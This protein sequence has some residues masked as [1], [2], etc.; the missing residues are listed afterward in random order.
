[1]TPSIKQNYLL[2]FDLSFDTDFELFLPT[3]YLTYRSGKALYIFKKATDS[4][5]QTLSELS[6]SQEENSLLQLTQSL[7]REVLL[8]KF[9]KDKSKLQWS[10]SLYDDS[11]K[12]QYIKDYVEEKTHKI[13]ETISREQLLL[14]VNAQHHKEIQAFEI[15]PKAKQITPFLEFEKTPTAIHYRMYLLDGQTKIAPYKQNIALLNNKYSWIAIGG[16][17]AQLENIKPVHL[18]GFLSKETIEIPQKTIGV[19]FEKFLKEI[20]KKVSIHPIGFEVLTQNEL[21]GVSIF[22]SHDFFINTYKVYL[23]WDY[24]GHY[25]FSNERKSSFSSLIQQQENDLQI[26]QFKRNQKQE[27]PYI[28]ALKNIGL[29]Y[30]SGW[31][32]APPESANLWVLETLIEHKSSLE[33]AG[34]DLTH[35]RLNDKKINLDLPK[36]ET[37]L[38][39]EGNDWFDIH[40]TIKQGDYQ[41]DFKDLIKNLK[42][43]NPIFEL[44]DGSVFI[45]PQAWFSKYGTLA[46]FTKTEQGKTRLAKN[47]FA[48]LGEL[49]ELQPQSL[50]TNISYTP[51]PRLK[52]TLRPYQQEG[53]RWL[54]EHYHNGLGACLADDMGLGKTLQTIALLVAVHDHLPEEEVGQMTL[55][56]EVEKQK[57]ALR[58][59]V[60]LPSSLVFNWYDE[61]KRF[62]PHFKCIQYIGNNRKRIT[63]RLINYDVVFTTYHTI[64]RDMSLLQKLDFRYIILDESQRIKNKDSQTFKAIGSLRGS[65]KISLSGTPIENS[66]S[67]LWAQMQFIN[68][69][70]LGSF[71]HFSNYFKNG[72]EKRQDPIVL[73]ELKTII[74]PFLLRRTKEQVL[75]DLPEMTE[76]IA[77][78]ELTAEQQKWYESE[79]SKARNALLK[80]DKSVL[81][82]HALNILT[83]LRQISN[84]PQLID[85]QSPITSGKYQE[86]VSHLEALIQSKQKA[87]IFSSFVKHLAIF[88]AWCEDKGIRYS[89][90][91]GEVRPEMRKE[92][93][94]QFQEEAE[95]QFF[96][97]SLKTGE[98]GLN[99]TA[100]SHVF[101]LDPWWNPFSEKQAIGRAHRIGQQN[102]VNVIR[103]VT[104]DTVEEKI[105]RLQQSK[106][107]LSQSIIQENVIIKDV[108]DNIESILM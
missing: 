104:K 25:F 93:V 31:L 91:T 40:I 75:D 28:K 62:A 81:T 48:L 94:T 21:K 73:E 106:K 100:A 26:I 8:K 60:I 64:T 98:V 77:Y 57:Q 79:K 66:L 50:K 16:H 65:H 83:R 43:N 35:I 44:P 87:L 84:H 85:P 5:L 13:L 96:F 7:Q 51:S 33:M 88:Q 55:F 82:T 10:A 4:V 68:P 38:T 101:L 108:I 72:I 11:S 39:Q 3:A 18:K 99:L 80:V 69:N 63:S 92:Q 24:Q 46:K 19:Y 34:F 22:L 58:A 12:K 71:S 61:T 17:L 6:L 78:C 20:L 9:L 27:E 47:N 59:L 53:V 105:I 97:I 107:A 42:D 49:P 67:D 41:F 89:T 95:V 37:A 70:I 2:C 23:R 15:H 54:L 56:A 74:S 36:I 45:I 30:E 76:Q 103:F 14:T 86:V 29:R 1:M 52:A 90:L 32:V 102:K